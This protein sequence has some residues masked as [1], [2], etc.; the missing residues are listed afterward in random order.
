MSR[1][2]HHRPWRIQLIDPD[3][4]STIV[5]DHDHRHGTCDLADLITNLKAG[6][7]K[8]T[9]CRLRYIGSRNLGCGCSLC[10]G[11]AGRRLANRQVRVA[12]RTHRANALALIDRDGLDIPP[13][14]G[15]AW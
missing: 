9:N 5:E 8:R 10:T 15:N 11:Q 13:L 3:D 12:W 2:Y 14:R 7:W 1:T 6:T 4:P